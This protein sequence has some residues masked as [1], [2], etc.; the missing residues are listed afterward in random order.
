MFRCGK[1]ELYIILKG[2]SIDYY[3][4]EEY[5]SRFRDSKLIS[6]K[7]YAF[8][9]YSEDTQK[10][11]KE[12]LHDLK[13]NNCK[14]LESADL[15]ENEKIKAFHLS[16]CM[17]AF[18]SH[19]YIISYEIGFLYQAIVIGK[20][21]ILYFC[22]KS[23]LPDEVLFIKGFDQYLHFD[24]GT[25]QDRLTKLI[26]WLKKNNC[27][28]N[29]YGIIDYEYK[30]NSNGSISIRK[31]TGKED[32]LIIPCEVQLEKTIVKITS[33]EFKAFANCD[34]SIS[35]KIPHGIETLK[36]YAFYL[37]KNL[38][39]VEIP[40]SVTHIGRCAF[41]GCHNLI[42]YCSKSSYTW[43]YCEKEHIPHK[44]LEELSE[45]KN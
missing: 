5:N 38:K 12:I 35:V 33:I 23:N 22:D 43:K 44:S 40:S 29:P 41:D 15:S 1:F 8:C 26:Q 7:G 25:Y 13:N 2:F 10:Q 16:D 4:Q 9:S 45:E 18:I 11:V 3:T 28:K 21:C 19:K 32:N 27:C 14:V 31:Y 20:P 42:I 37:C 30:T 36:D 39:S 17:I 34:S 24:I 6:T